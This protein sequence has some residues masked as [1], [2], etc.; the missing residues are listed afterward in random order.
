MNEPTDTAILMGYESMR[1]C[2]GLP[3]RVTPPKDVI[4]WMQLALNIP[5]A[6]TVAALDTQVVGSFHFVVDNS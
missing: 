5:T 3:T 6:E 4:R 1:I 2:L